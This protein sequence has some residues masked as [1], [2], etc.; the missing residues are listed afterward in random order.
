MKRIAFV[1]GGA[2]VSEWSGG[3]EQAPPTPAGCLVVD[4]T[5]RAESVTGYTWNG[6]TFT[7]PAPAKA[8]PDASGFTDRE[9]LEAIARRLGVL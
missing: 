1:K 7:A 8:K 5:A 9:L 2:V 6:S 4:V 3:V